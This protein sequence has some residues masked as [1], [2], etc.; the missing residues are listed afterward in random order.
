LADPILD[1]FLAK[2][3]PKHLPVS[4]TPTKTRPPRA[5]AKALSV[6]M[7]SRSKPFLNSTVSD[8]RHVAGVRIVSQ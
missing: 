2:I 5:L 7:V 3:H 1:G 6:S 4:E 8:A